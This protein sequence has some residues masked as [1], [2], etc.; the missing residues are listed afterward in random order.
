MS[1]EPSV[2]I[3][4]PAYNAEKTIARAVRSALGEPGVQEVVVID[5]CSSDNTVACAQTCDDGTGRLKVLK[6]D[7]N[8]GPAAARNR[9]IR[10]STSPWLGLLDSDDFLLPGRIAGLWAYTNDADMVADD[11]WQVSEENPDGPKRLVLGEQIFL[12]RIVGFQEFVLSNITKPG[13]ERRELGFIKPL[14]R[15]TFLETHGISYREDMR[16]G[17]DYDLYARALAA[18]G[19]LLLVPAQGYV[20]VIRANSL[21]GQHT[22]E[23][24]RLLRDCN[25]TIEQEFELNGKDRK[26]LRRHYRNTD[27]RLQWRL[28]INAV[29]NRD[30][31]SGVATFVRP[32][33]VP[34]YLLGKLGEQAVIRGLRLK[35]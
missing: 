3:I 35:A 2:C 32:W 7:K 23:D 33:P 25:R 31:L 6:Q 17:E 27:C 16:L 11:L 20:A 12:P 14:M 22:E 15:R 34:L 8:G 1:T 26:A 19:R 5:D 30:I 24:L 28:L 4:I 29:K 21:S 9:A 10:E 18:G 13:R